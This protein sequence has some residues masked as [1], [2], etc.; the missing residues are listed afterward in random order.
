MSQQNIRLHRASGELSTRM[1]QRRNVCTDIGM[2]HQFY[3]DEGMVA[4][5]RTLE[6][7]WSE[8]FSAIDNG[9]LTKRQQ[10][11]YCRKWSKVAQRLDQ[12][13]NG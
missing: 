7:L 11:E 6:Y 13:V 1:D 10:Y 9:N 4:T 5:P 2:I 12:I 8:Y 3:N